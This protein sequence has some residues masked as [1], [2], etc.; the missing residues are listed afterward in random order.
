MNKYVVRTS[1]VWIGI[2]AVA[3]AGLFL[4]RS[5]KAATP[6]RTK[7]SMSAEEQPVAEGPAPAPASQPANMPAMGGSS[8]TPTSQ[9]PMQMPLTPV[10]ITAQRMQ[11][12]GV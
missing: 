1:L 11:S 9:A 5:H 8:T 12:I 7:S 3:I 6:A 10:Q 2:L 4:Y